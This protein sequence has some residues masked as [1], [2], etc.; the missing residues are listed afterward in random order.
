MVAHPEK[1]GQIPVGRRKTSRLRLGIPAVLL[2]LDGTFRCRLIDLSC[3]G[4]RIGLDQHLR[5]GAEAVLQC[6]GFEVFGMVVW[7]DAEQVG[8]HFD[9]ELPASRLLTLRDYKDNSRER[10]LAEL[11]RSVHDWVNGGGSRLV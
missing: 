10:S 4:A 1:S 8:M 5:I 3:S 9:E 11:R 7:S 6:P 2:L